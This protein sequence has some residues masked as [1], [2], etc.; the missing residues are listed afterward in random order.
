MRNQSFTLTEAIAYT[1]ESC[2]SCG[3]VF[4]LTAEFQRARMSDKARFYCPNGHSQ[5]Y[6]GKSD[7]E[8]AYE[9]NQARHKAEMRLQ[10]EVDQRR[11]RPRA[12]RQGARAE[13]APPAS[14]GRRLP[15]LQPDVR[16][17]VAPHQ[18][19][20]PRVPAM[21]GARIFLGK[22]SDPQTIEDVVGQVMGAA[23]ACWED[24]GSAGRF[25]AEVAAE[26]YDEAMWWIKSRYELKPEFRDGEPA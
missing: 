1:T 7:R 17:A 19:P 18:E 2:C 12:Q 8:L 3:V 13:T 22:P 9:A 24:L 14:E 6:I 20:A 26:I 16:A 4:A 5:S 23:S 10:A 21:S 15:V 11:R 25:Q